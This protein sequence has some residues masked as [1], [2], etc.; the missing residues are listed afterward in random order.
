MKK[1]YGLT[2]LLFLTVLCLFAMTNTNVYSQPCTGNTIALRYGNLTLTAPNKAEFDIEVKNTGTTN[3]GVAA[4]AG[5]FVY[6]VAALDAGTITATSTKLSLASTLNNLN[7]TGNLTVQLA[8]S[9][10]RWAHTPISGTFVPLTGPGV[11]ATWQPFYHITITN[12]KPFSLCVPLTLTPNYGTPIGFSNSIATIYCNGNP[13]S[14][15]LSSTNAGT[16]DPIS[17][18]TYGNATYVCPTIGTSANII[19]PVCYGGTGSAEITLTSTSA[20]PT[21]NG[22]YTVDGGTAIYYT[23]NP[24]TVTNL[25]T[26][27][28]T[29][30]IQDTVQQ[31]CSPFQVLVTIAGPITPLKN[32]SSQTACNSYLWA[33]SNQTYTASGAY[34]SISTN[35]QGCTITDSLYLTITPTSS[36]SASITAC[37]SYTWAITNQIITSSGTY[38]NVAGCH[39]DSLL[40]TIL[41]P[42]YTSTTITACDSYTW[43]NQTYTSSGNYVYSNPNGCDVDTLH[44]TIAPSI[45]SNNSISACNNYLWQA[46]NQTYST[47]GTYY[48]YLNC[49]NDTLVLTILPGTGATTSTTTN[50]C[51]SYTWQLNNQTYTMSGTY[52][53]IVGCDI[54]SLILTITQSTSTSNSITACDNYTWTINTQNYTSSGTYVNIIGCNTDSLI[55]T[56]TP[57]TTSNNAVTSCTD[58]TWTI[59]NQTYT[60]SGIYT[61]NIGCS[62][63]TLDLTI[64]APTTT[65]ENIITCGSY[66]WS[67]NNQ[68]YTSDGIY[69]DTLQNVF[70]CD[71]IINLNLTFIPFPI[72]T[73]TD[74]SICEG[75]SADFLSSG[76]TKYDFIV[77]G[78]SAQFGL[79]DHF[80]PTNIANNDSVFV[81]MNDDPACYSE[82]IHIIV[83][84]NPII[85][86]QA[87]PTSLCLGASVNLTPYGSTPNTDYT[88]TTDYTNY[89]P[90]TV[91]DI[92]SSTAQQIYLISGVDANG[93]SAYTSVF[94][95]ITMPSGFLSQSNN[96]N[97][98]SMSGIQTNSYLQPD[99]AS[100]IYFDQNCEI[101]LSLYDSTGG[102][103]LEVTEATVEVDN[104]IQTWNNQPYVQRHYKITPTNPGTSTVTL[105]LTQGDFDEYN[106][107]ASANGWPLLPTSSSDL[108]GMANLRITK[109]SGGGLGVGIP[110]VITPTLLWD[111][112]ANYWQVIFP[113]STFSEFYF[114]TVNQ[115]NAPLPINL[116]SFTGHMNDNHNI[117]NWITS[118][119]MNNA[120][121]NL[122]HSTDASNFTTIAN[123]QSKA[124]NGNSQSELNYSFTDENPDALINYYRLQLIDL[125][126]KTTNMSQVIELSRTLIDNGYSMYPNPTNGLLNI[127]FNADKLTNICFKIYDITGRLVHQIQSI[128]SKG[129]N[130]T[131]VDIEKFANGIYVLEIIENDKVLNKIRVNKQN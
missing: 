37:N 118:S 96:G 47:S 103:N 91:A 20:I 52:L 77:N 75:L 102:S 74:T 115:A 68:T 81:I 34:E 3:L 22:K 119:E 106:L 112:G 58:Y 64:I 105:Y 60:S 32:V 7:T 104:A 25:S 127:D 59:N 55:L 88:W 130:H 85:D 89:Y 98:T 67:I 43:N 70:G 19:D 73:A 87:I 76:G 24:F 121:F 65:N 56:I 30:V 40:L 108:Q 71:S 44:L 62:T 66:T 13:N 116:L 122:Q 107:Y 9:Q 86:V 39:T 15:S 113:I 31:C 51:D 49:N 80:S 27:T 35:G 38:I 11:T 48:S 33:A 92:P 100:M 83:N 54:D 99:G 4:L 128:S 50:A 57:S 95:N 41:T 97:A 61:S 46:N 90:V 21:T 120:S 69:S 101:I 42:V 16:M 1:N 114:H 117:L 29:L 94:V 26:G 72:L 6:N 17:P 111:A 23:T 109:L 53:N 5:G 126:G 125:D 12:S 123:I 8:T 18:V 45:S 28:H 82:T 124:I 78:V 36:N 10:V 79:S 93:C 129:F 2:H 84:P 14:V 110:T 63:D 131:T